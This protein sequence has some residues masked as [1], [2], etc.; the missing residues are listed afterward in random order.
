MPY[1]KWVWTPAGGWYCHPPNWQ[2]NT[3]IAA[4]VWVVVLAG[5]FN[6]SAK[7]ERRL[8]PPDRPI[9]SQLWCK[10]AY[11]DDPGCVFA[12]KPAEAEE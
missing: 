2:R 8:N 12:P 6:I 10:H 1:P 4:C 7:L 11:T 5:V 3:K 9:A